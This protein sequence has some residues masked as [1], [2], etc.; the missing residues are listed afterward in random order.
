MRAGPT[1]HAEKRATAESVTRALACTGTDVERMNWFPATE[2]LDAVP[3]FLEARSYNQIAQLPTEK[4][5]TVL[6]F[7]VESCS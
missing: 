6:P 5:A 4:H 3:Q 7:I 2:M 1:M